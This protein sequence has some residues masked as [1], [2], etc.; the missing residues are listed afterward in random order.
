MDIREKLNYIKQL[1]I[2]D[3]L[4]SLNIYPSKIVNCNYWY[5]S[6]L[7][8]EKTPSFK[9]DRTK[10]LWFDFG[11]GKGGSLIDF[12]LLYK[13]WTIGDLIRNSNGN[14]PNSISNIPAPAINKKADHKIEIL[15][16]KTISSYPLVDY[17][18][19]RKIPLDVAQKYCSEIHYRLGEKEYYAIGFKND[20][21]GYEL[22]NKYM[23]LSTSPKDH[24]T[25][26][27]N[28]TRI[29]V[30]E[31]FFD[32]LSFIAITKNQQPSA[33]FLI[34]NSLSFFEKAKHILNR[35]DN[36]D[37]FLDNDA[38][39]QN[40]SQAA[41]Q[42]NSNYKDQSKLYSQNKDLNEWLILFGKQQKQKHSGLGFK[43]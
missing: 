9:V 5:T 23:K 2:V 13:D 25:L 43:T 6:P 27:N 18:K 19:S 22:R 31:G 8:N 17:L 29:C 42:E 3:H 14:Y 11:L 40:C 24:T 20:S 41:C 10:N 33:D 12:I 34:L 21:G 16:S 4:E 39:G 30:F 28:A 1:N 37:L 26:L 36:V 32:F 35:Y 38:P 15:S 7:R